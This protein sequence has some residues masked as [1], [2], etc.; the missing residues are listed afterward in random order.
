[1]LEALWVPRIE[2]ADGVRGV[3]RM[4]LEVCPEGYILVRNS[5]RPEQDEC[6]KCPPL[7]YATVK[8]SF[9]SSVMT[10]ASAVLLRDKLNLCLPCPSGGVCTQGGASV[11]YSRHVVGFKLR[12]G[13]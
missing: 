9:N 5:S 3:T 13:A 8:A 12:W 4:R 2:S 7:S 1:M 6:A 11:R 10:S